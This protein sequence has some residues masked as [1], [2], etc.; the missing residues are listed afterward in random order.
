MS[1][2]AE[3]FVERGLVHHLDGNRYR[4]LPKAGYNTKTYLVTFSNNLDNDRCTCQFYSSG[5][6]LKQ[7]KGCSHWYAVKI[8]LNQ[9]ESVKNG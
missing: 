6:W 1:G 2:K 7:K 4:I 5:N 3:S 9:K 8:F